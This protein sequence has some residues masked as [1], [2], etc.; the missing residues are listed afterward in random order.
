MK[1]IT[2][3]ILMML[4][5]GA[6]TAATFKSDIT[7]QGRASYFSKSM[8]DQQLADMIR[9]HETLTA[10]STLTYADCGKTFF[11]NATTEFAT[12]LPTPIAGCMATFYIKA[13]PVGS[14]YTVV[15]DSGD[16][17]IYGEAVVNGAAIAAVTEDTITFTASAAAIGDWVTLYSD[18]T[19]WYVSGQGVAATAIAFTAT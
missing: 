8:T 4:I 9:D 2:A 6:A 17:V 16:N 19:N 10:A 3:F 12:T 5:I 1:K 15:T 11:L 18:G 7:T 14:S 13:A